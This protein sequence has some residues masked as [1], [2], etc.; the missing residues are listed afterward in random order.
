MEQPADR[1]QVSKYFAGIPK[2]VIAGY[3]KACPTC[4][5]KTTLTASDHP[6]QRYKL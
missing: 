3:V 4:R 1:T 2:E 6:E 5:A